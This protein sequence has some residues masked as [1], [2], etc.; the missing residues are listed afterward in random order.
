MTMH[1]A[2]RTPVVARHTSRRGSAREIAHADTLRGFPEL[3]KQLGGEP[4]A[5][6]ER[7]GIDPAVLHKPGSVIDYRSRLR[8]MECAAHELSCPDF[9]LRLAATQSAHP[10]IGPIGV[11]M[12]NC[13]TLGEAMKLWV[14]HNYAYTRATRARIE[15]E[16]SKHQ[17]VIR[18][19]YL[20]DG[21]SDRRQAVEH[22]LLLGALHVVKITGGAVRVQRIL[23]SHEPHSPLKT[24]RTYFGC[25][26]NFGEREDG[27]V[28]NAR[29]LLS[30]IVN[31]DPTVY[32]IATSFLEDRFPAKEPPLDARV[33]SIVLQQLRSKDCT[34]ARVAAELYTHPRTLQRRLRATGASFEGIKDEIRREVALRYIGEGGMSL[35]RLAEM[36][37]YAETSIVSRNFHRWFSA[38][39]HELMHRQRSAI[40]M[41]SA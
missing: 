37:G 41:H 36:L 7:A 24:Y 9:G 21:A 20:I 5:L 1:V 14:R 29:D 13:S 32:E 31:A 18:V 30:P 40:T 33:R 28:F 38:T 26:V 35:K 23:L 6:L 27:M 22:G 3:V 19:E 16:H 10:A 11:V 15:P 34:I 2:N 17:V 12:K 4:D 39:P 8:I 25:D